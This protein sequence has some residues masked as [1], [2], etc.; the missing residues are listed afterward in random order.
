MHKNPESTAKT[1]LTSVKDILLG[2]LGFGVVLASTHG[3]ILSD[4]H[5]DLTP[6][7]FTAKITSELHTHNDFQIQN[8]H[9]LVD[10]KHLR[11]VRSE[12]DKVAEN[13]SLRGNWDVY[14]A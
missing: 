4:H 13:D 12:G 11:H 2:A 10:P 6:T 9:L 8:S 14:R 3:A 1:P 5:Q 7:D